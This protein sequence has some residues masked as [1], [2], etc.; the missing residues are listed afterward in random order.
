[1]NPKVDAYLGKAKRW[2][3]ECKLL[4][5]FVLDSELTEE[6][7]WGVPCYTYNGKNVAIIHGFKEYCGLMFF[8]GSLFKDP[9]G[10]L[11]QQTANVQ[12]PRQIRFT[13]VKDVVKMKASIKACIKEAIAVEKAGLK[14][15]LKKTED[16]AV[17]E[18][19]Q[20]QLDKNKAFNKAFTSLTPGRQRAYILHFS[21]AQQSQTRADRVKKW[22][23]HILQGKGLHD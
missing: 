22:T 16:F 5:M 20:T 6:L 19:L 14:V 13:A 4:R 2:Q 3:E 8:K 17:P 15:E 10:I 12:G 1:M 11:I 21:G 7:K 9:R 23:P 18:E